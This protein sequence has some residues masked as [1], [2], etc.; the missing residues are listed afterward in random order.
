M[1]ES[2]T[3]SFGIPFNPQVME[4]RISNTAVESA[5][6]DFVMLTS[7]PPSPRSLAGS[8]LSYLDVTPSSKNLQLHL[9]KAQSAFP[10]EES[11]EIAGQTRDDVPSFDTPPSTPPDCPLKV[12]AEDMELSS[13]AEQLQLPNIAPATVTQIPTSTAQDIGPLPSLLRYVDR[14]LIRDITL[15]NRP[16]NLSA[17]CPIC[18]NIYNQAPIQTTFLPLTPCGCWVHYRCFIWHVAQAVPSHSNCP[19]CNL[20]LFEWEGITALTLAAR[21]SIDLQNTLFP[22]Y[23][24]YTDSVT[25]TVVTCDY[26]AYAADCTA[27][28]TLIERTFDTHLHATTKKHADDSPDLTVCYYGVLDAL[29]KQN[30]PHARWL[31]WSTATGFLLFGMLVVVKMRRFLVESQERIVGTLGWEEFEK[32]RM[33]LQERILKEVWCEGVSERTGETVQLGERR[34]QVW[35]RTE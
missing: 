25:G 5:H 3:T 33:Q 30:R 10:I 27:I 24:L 15:H 31:Q 28:D 14:D 9:K 6:S 19:V 29:D 8:A 32:G 18:H 1:L 12:E 7:S 22:S 35:V 20:V 34:A 2:Q 11:R 26:S 21:T 16:P 23:M 17:T 13:Q 4:S